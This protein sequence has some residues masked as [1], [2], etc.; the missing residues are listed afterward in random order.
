MQVHVL[1]TLAMFA[2][3]TAYRL[4]AEQAAVGDEPV[5]WQRG[6]KMARIM[7][8]LKPLSSMCITPT[9]STPL[10]STVLEPSPWRTEVSS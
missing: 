7:L 6:P 1:F 2:L 8:F 5:G 10:S 4:R 3:A 9:P